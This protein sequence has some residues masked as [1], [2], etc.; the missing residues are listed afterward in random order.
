MPPMAHLSEEEIC[1]ITGYLF[2]EFEQEVII[3]SLTAVKRGEM[4]LKSNC[5]GIDLYLKI[6]INFD[7]E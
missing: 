5:T 6:T 1:A 4:L 2:G 7:Q 3:V